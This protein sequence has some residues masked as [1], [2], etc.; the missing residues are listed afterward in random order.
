MGFP[1]TYNYTLVPC[2]NYGK[3]DHLATSNKIDF[4]NLWNFNAS[5]F[6]T[7]K[8]RIDG[9]QLLLTDK[10]TFNQEIQEIHNSLDN[11]VDA[12]ILE[13]Y[14]HNG[15]AGSYEIKGKKS[16]SGI[17]TTLIYLNTIDGIS[18]QKIYGNKYI[19]NFK[20]IAGQN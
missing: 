4:K 7:W 16:Y 17:F 2:M 10:S 6:T 15:F 18:K 14:D 8:Y 1:F 5:E 3:L 13:F 19:D 12:L 11:K 20:E 9:N